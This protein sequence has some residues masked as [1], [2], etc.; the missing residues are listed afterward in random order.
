MIRTAVILAAGAGTRL[1]ELGTRY[2][3]PMVPLCG[4]PLIDWVIERLRAAGLTRFVIVA[5]AGDVA[6]QRHARATGADL[7][8]QTERRG[9]ADALWCAKPLLDEDPSFLA[10]ACDSLFAIADLRRMLDVAAA[11]PDDAVV[12][13]QTLDAGATAARSAVVRDG[14][15]VRAI[16][17][18]PP[19]GSAPSNVISLPLYV[20]PH[21]MVARAAATAPLRGE[22]YLSTAL[23]DEV[24]AGGRVRW[25]EFR[26]RLEIT[27]ADDLA[28]VE[29]ILA[30][31]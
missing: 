16:I 5:H 22:R 10:C 7:A 24:A 25:I 17:E 23:S 31:T 13:V 3:K 2:S 28:R 30:T 8:L 14:D 26:E 4:R 9:I 18:K 21:R 19:A 15:F 20:L 12:A 1:G 29:A 11:Y 6:L 27:T